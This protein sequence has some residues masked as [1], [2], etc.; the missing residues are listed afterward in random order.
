M[1]LEDVQESWLYAGQ[2]AIKF[3]RQVGKEGVSL[4]EFVA[5]KAGSQREWQDFSVAKCVAE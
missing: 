4:K 5:K 3:E 1:T 2:E